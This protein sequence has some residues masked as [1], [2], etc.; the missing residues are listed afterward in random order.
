MKTWLIAIC[1][2]T[3]QVITE[4]LYALHQ[5]GRKVDGIRILTTREGKSK[6]YSSLMAPKEGHY[7]R[8]LKDYG[9]APDTIDFSSRHIRAVCDDSGMEIDDITCGEDNELFLRACMETAFELTGNQ[10]NSV[11]F[12]IAG[13]RK[14]MGACL[15]LAAQ[16]Y[17]RPQDRICHVLVSPEFENCRDFFYPPPVSEAVTLTDQL[18]QPYN[19]ETRY[20]RV[21]LIPMP[22]FS[23]RDRLSDRL[24]KVPESP[25]TLMLSLVHDR[26]GE[27]IVDIAARKVSWKGIE[28]DLMPARM[29]LFTFFVLLKK[30]GKC[31][32]PSCKCCRDCFLSTPEIIRR[33]DEIAALYR[34]MAIRDTEEMSDS[35]I[36]SLN[37][38][39]LAMYRSRLNEDLQRGF[40]AQEVRHF[41]VT[42]TGRKP[43]KQYG[44]P[45]DRERIKVIL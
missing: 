19:K 31:L 28:V 12:S 45:L 4:T 11:I 29:A 43:N 21:T 9:I 15:A 39:N 14:T 17:G 1:G 32:K 34:R 20:A 13:G 36:Q 22:F 2:L 6:I 35:G 18:G 38:E 16:A 41:E 33:S 24:L 10:G 42:A 5:Q 30:E 3:P 27:M 25:A 23:I 40:G 37:K 44:I 7:Y 8:Y 26:H